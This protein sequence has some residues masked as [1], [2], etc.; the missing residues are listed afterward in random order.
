[1]LISQ[2][3]LRISFAGGG[4]DLED[5]YRSEEGTVISTAIDKYIFV[6]VKERYD[7][8]IVLSWTIKEIVNNINEIQHDLIREGLLLTKAMKGLEVITTADIPS[9]GSG[10]G[11]SSAVT[12]GL[13]NAFHTF[14][15]TNTIFLKTRS[16][17]CIFLT[18]WCKLENRRQKFFFLQL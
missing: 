8:K 10:L 6:L 5:Y 9:E 12:V 1:M 2:T 11:S 14:Q 13:L 4:T 7:D 16:T 17:H 15:S 18:Y 3:P